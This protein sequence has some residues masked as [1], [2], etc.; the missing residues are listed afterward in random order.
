ME[1]DH[2]FWTKPSEQNSG[3]GRIGSASIL[4]PHAYD[5]ATNPELFEGFWC[6]AS[7]PSS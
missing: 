1:I 7:S 4:K 5:P 2:K 3:A 6:G